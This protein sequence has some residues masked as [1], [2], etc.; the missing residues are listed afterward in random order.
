MQIWLQR[1]HREHFLFAQIVNIREVRLPLAV[2]LLWTGKWDRPKLGGE[3][4]KNIHA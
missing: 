4:S 1:Y 3:L 2:F